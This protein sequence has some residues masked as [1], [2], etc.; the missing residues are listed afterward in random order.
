MYAEW[1][2]SSGSRGWDSGVGG[3]RCWDCVP[4]IGWKGGEEREL[5]PGLIR[6]CDDAIF[7]SVT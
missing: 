1:A 5:P 7:L 6:P 4:G 3:W 2:C